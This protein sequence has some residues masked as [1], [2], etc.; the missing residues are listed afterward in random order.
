MHNRS[1]HLLVHFLFGVACLLRSYICYLSQFWII[2]EWRIDL[3]TTRNIHQFVQFSNFNQNITQLKFYKT[4]TLE[5]RPS[6][7]HHV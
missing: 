6:Q 5:I 4:V 2:H 1:H 3:S 7:D